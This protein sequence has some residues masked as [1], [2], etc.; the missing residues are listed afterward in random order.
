M[1]NLS[2]SHRIDKYLKAHPSGDLLIAVG[3][4][5][6]AGVAWLAKR[7]AGRSGSVSLLIGDTRS[8]WWKKAKRSDRSA[9]LAFFNRPDV[10]VKNWYRTKK[11]PSGASSAHLKVWATHEDWEPVSALVGSGNLTTKGLQGNVEVMVEAYRQDMHE[12]WD[13]AHG[14]WQKAWPCAERLAKYMGA[15][16]NRSAAS[17]ARAAVPSTPSGRSQ[18]SP[19]PAPTQPRDTNGDTEKRS[20][21]QIILYVISG[22]VALVGLT[23]A[24]QSAFG[25]TL[26]MLLVAGLVFVWAKRSG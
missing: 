21:K 22:L 7:T 23:A 24:G 25:G 1:I 16:L 6:P 17:P 10:E 14:V 11:S 13:A 15:T 9:C 12:A 2:A 5:T 8:H 20:K 19:A 18:Q 3:Y 4:A 26:V